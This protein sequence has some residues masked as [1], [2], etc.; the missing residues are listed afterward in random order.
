MLNHASH[1][2][3]K[4]VD[5][6][7]YDIPMWLSESLEPQ[8]PVL[9]KTILAAQRR[10][11]IFSQRHHWQHHTQEPF[12]KRFRVHSDKAA[13]D[14]DLLEICGLDPHWF[15]DDLSFEVH[16]SHNAVVLVNIQHQVSPGKSC[17]QLFLHATLSL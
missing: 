1:S 16:A 7:V 14:H 15:D 13:F 10:L 11:R 3:I 8:R 6:G 9:Q 2:Q 5:D 12:A 4:Q 17:K